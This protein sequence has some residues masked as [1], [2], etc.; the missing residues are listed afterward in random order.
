MSS[1]IV[2]FEQGFDGRTVRVVRTVRQGDKLLSRDA[3]ASTYAPKDWIKR[4]GTEGCAYRGDGART[5]AGGGRRPQ[6]VLAMTCLQTIFRV[7]KTPSPLTAQASTTGDCVWLSS[8]FKSST[9]K[10]SLRSRLFI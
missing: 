2:T 6:A 3:F 8:S 7:S 5:E 4:I 9:E 10:M 1:G